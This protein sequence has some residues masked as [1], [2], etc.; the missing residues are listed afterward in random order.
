LQKGALGTNRRKGGMALTKDTLL[1]GEQ[2]NELEG[3]GR[4]QTMGE[5]EEEA[6]ARKEML[7]GL[8]EED[9]PLSQDVSLEPTPNQE[10]SS[11]SAAAD[12]AALITLAE[13]ALDTLSK[14]ALNKKRR[15]QEGNSRYKELVFKRSDDSS[16]WSMLGFAGYRIRL[17]WS[18]SCFVLRLHPKVRSAGSLSFLIFLN[19]SSV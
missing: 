8:G 5:K 16:S 4:E 13:P 19:R 6:L 15:F 3:Q 18:S 10:T 2:A 14:S 11:S 12:A 7:A 17:P 9:L 1:E